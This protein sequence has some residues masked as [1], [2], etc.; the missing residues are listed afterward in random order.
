MCWRCV[1]CWRWPAAQR[2]PVSWGNVAI[3]PPR[4]A[5]T[6]TVSASVRGRGRRDI[7]CPSYSPYLTSGGLLGVGT[8]SPTATLQVSGSF[9]VSTSPRQPHPSLYVGTNGNVGIGTT[10]PLAD[11]DVYVA[12]AVAF[13]GQFLAKTDVNVPGYGFVGTGDGASSKDLTWPSLVATKYMVLYQHG[14]GSSGYK[15]TPEVDNQYW[16]GKD[17]EGGQPSIP[18]NS[19][20][21]PAYHRF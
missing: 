12:P 13:N 15:I 6:L 7:G 3:S 14:G 4:W 9:I 11:L 17:N 5:S 10:S 18:I 8:S 16:M 20:E 2:M 21:Q 1:Q 19:S